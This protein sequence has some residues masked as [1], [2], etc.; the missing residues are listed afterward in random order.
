[1]GDTTEGA[2][3]AGGPAGPAADGAKAR[4][5]RLRRLT[6]PLCLPLASADNTWRLYHTQRGDLAEQ[7][8]ELQLRGR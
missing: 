6:L 2:Q 8:F 5:L 3:A 4:S 1:M 7:T